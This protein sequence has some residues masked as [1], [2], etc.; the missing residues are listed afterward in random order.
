MFSIWGVNR[1]YWEPEEAAPVGADAALVGVRCEA[2]QL[3]AT[4]AAWKGT[5][6]AVSEATVVDAVY[7][8]LAEQRGYCR[9]V[10]VGLAK[11]PARGLGLD[12]VLNVNG[13]R[14]GE[15]SVSSS[16]GE[17]LTRPSD[18]ID[19]VDYAY[20]SVEIVE[21]LNL[22]YA[23]ADPD[24]RTYERAEIRTSIR[25]ERKAL[26]PA[27]RPS[28]P[29]PYRYLVSETVDFPLVLDDG[30]PTIRADAKTVTLEVLAPSASYEV[31]VGLT[32]DESYL[33][34][35]RPMTNPMAA[36]TMTAGQ[37]PRITTAPFPRTPVVIRLEEVLKETDL[38]DQQITVCQRDAKI[39]V[40][41]VSFPSA[42]NPYQLR[43]TIRRLVQEGQ[44]VLTAG[45]L[46][47]VADVRGRK[48]LEGKYSAVARKAVLTDLP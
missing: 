22:D 24:G 38:K 2:P 47:I 23:V 40:V 8:Q 11:S 16:Y 1:W 39:P 5:R 7:R 35:E 30:T 43:T 17:A 12:Y 25:Y 20:I 33:E 37:T 4:Y 31:S 34:D 27:V 45:E 28:R 13:R 36:V 46:T 32:K 42:P 44:K 21:R 41:L 29:S 26:A 3:L 6:T 18:S 10:V 14:Y 9:F 15:P 48:V 19:T